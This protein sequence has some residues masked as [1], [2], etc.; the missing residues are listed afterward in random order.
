MKRKHIHLS[1]DDKYGHWWLEMDGTESY[2]WWPKDHVGLTDTFFGT[3]G[4]LNGQTNFGGTP[5]ADP[6]Q[7]DSAEEEFNPTVSKDDGRSDD[8]IKECLRS[9]ANSYSGGWSWPFGQ[10]C[11]SFQE[12]AMK[13]CRL[14]KP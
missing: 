10:N 3:E 8:D 6:H 4:E 9:F 13:H 5:T 2:G 7:G 1:G 11:H 14:C 12:A